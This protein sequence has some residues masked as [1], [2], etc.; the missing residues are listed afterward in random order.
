MDSRK[1]A[2][3]RS[4]RRRDSGITHSSP[5]EGSGG[6]NDLEDEPTCSEAGTR[7]SH[8]EEQEED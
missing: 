2:R 8:P 3:A 7:T 4:R 6:E 5:S 1:A